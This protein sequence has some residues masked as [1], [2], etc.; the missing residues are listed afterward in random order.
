VERIVRLRRRREHDPNESP[1][2]LRPSKEVYTRP[3][4][5]LLRKGQAGTDH[6]RQSPAE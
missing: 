3:V 6:G 5:F 2:V 1:C 4:V